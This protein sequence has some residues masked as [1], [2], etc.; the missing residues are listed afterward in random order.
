MQYLS[1]FEILV[2]ALKVRKDIEMPKEPLDVLNKE[3][4]HFEDRQFA[5]QIPII[6]LITA[7][8]K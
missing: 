5:D 3:E 8:F 6:A 4:E 1:N 2:D 7:A